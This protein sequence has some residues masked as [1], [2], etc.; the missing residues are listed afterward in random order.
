[1]KDG[2]RRRGIKGVE[3]G[4]KERS[5]NEWNQRQSEGEKRNGLKGGRRGMKDKVD[6]E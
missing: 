6:K 1:M 2:K 5:G 3:N 4:R